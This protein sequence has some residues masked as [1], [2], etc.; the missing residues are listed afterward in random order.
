ML[1]KRFLIAEHIAADGMLVD[2][3]TCNM[4]HIVMSLSIF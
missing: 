4:Y 2:S 1:K 3:K